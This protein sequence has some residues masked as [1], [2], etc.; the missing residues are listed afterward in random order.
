MPKLSKP[1]EINTPEQVLSFKPGLEIAEFEVEVINQSDQF[2]SFQL[3]L[4]SGESGNHWYVLSPE[5]SAKKPPGSKTRFRVRI[6]DTPVPGFI[7]RMNLLVLV[8]SPELRQQERRIVRLQVEASATQ[9]PL[10][11][12]L[13]TRNFEQRPYDRFLIPVTVFNPSKEPII[14]AVVRITGKDQDRTIESWLEKAEEPL[15]RLTSGTREI[16]FRCRVPRTTEASN[17]LFTVGIYRGNECLDSTEGIVNILP[18]GYV[19]FICQPMM[20]H[21]GGKGWLLGRADQTATY[22]LVLDNQSNLPQQTRV[23]LEPVEGQPS[24]RC[25]MYLATPEP[26]ADLEMAVADDRATTNGNGHYPV[27]R[28]ASL[29]NAAVSFLEGNEDED[30]YI[31]LEPLQR[32]QFN[33]QVSKPSRPWFGLPRKYLFLVRAQM[34]EQR[35]DVRNDTQLLRLWMH[36]RLPLKTQAL[37][38]VVLLGLLWFVLLNPLF[39]HSRAV[40]SVQFNGTGDRLVS[41]SDDQSLMAWRVPGFFSPFHKRNLGVLGRTGKSVRVVRYRPV[42]NDLVAAGLENGDVQ[43]WS[44]IAP[45]RNPIKTLT[46]QRDDRVLD[47]AFSRDARYLFS[48]HGS[49]TVQQWPVDRLLS[50]PSS[51]QQQALGSTPALGFAAYALAPIGA[52]DK[53]LAIGGQFNRLVLW[54]WQTNRQKLLNYPPGSKD[55]YILSLATAEYQPALLAVSDNRGNLTVMN[56]TE[57][58]CEIVESWQGSDRPLHSVA[59]SPNGCYLASAGDDGK[60]RVWGLGSDAKRLP[61]SRVGKVVASPNS[62]IRSVALTQQQEDLLIA[63]GSEDTRVRVMR[64]KGFNSSCGRR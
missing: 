43:I 56:C 10:R 20:Q 50:D 1:I 35:L 63:L 48:S 60:V 15:P 27:S 49:G 21:L 29:A 42:S 33:L 51:L 55:D 23:E 9:V 46:R 25:E 16:T 26:R 5:V 30:P 37:G 18:D 64:Q 31:P 2:A 22:Q 59:L 7:G 52:V 14:D 61:E 34:Q 11:V 45:Q 54:N 38:G 40:N 32:V 39:K 12:N 3:E 36:P 57:D 47:L 41:A 62:Q 4:E 24:C 44:V 17:H 53:T 19:D 28:L 13:P 58:N 8:S 6:L